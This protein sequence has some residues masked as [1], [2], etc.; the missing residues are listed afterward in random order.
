MCAFGL[1]ACECTFDGYGKGLAAVSINVQQEQDCLQLNE[2]IN[3]AFIWLI[4][5]SADNFQVQLNEPM[6]HH[7]YT[8]TDGVNNRPIQQ[9]DL[10]YR[11]GEITQQKKSTLSW[12]RFHGGHKK[13]YKFYLQ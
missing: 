3:T 13:P 7:P 6:F 4:G 12:N 5:F 1:I 8:Y 11:F 2:Q 10:F 9:H